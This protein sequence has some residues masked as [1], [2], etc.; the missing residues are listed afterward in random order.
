MRY[1]SR[2]L[3]QLSTLRDRYVV[4]TTVFCLK[5][6]RVVQ[7]LL[8]FATIKYLLK[9]E[10][11]FTYHLEH[12][13]PIWYSLF[14]LYIDFVLVFLPILHDYPLYSTD[15]LTDISFLCVCFFCQPVLFSSDCDSFNFDINSFHSRIIN[16]CHAFVFKVFC[17][18]YNTL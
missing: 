2:V 9:E 3:N 13:Y 4:E 15:L 16:V 10:Q 18:Y 11:Q 14:F 8:N 1:F 5:Y 17:R 6:S 7:F 12:C